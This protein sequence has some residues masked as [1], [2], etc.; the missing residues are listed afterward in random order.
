MAQIIDTGQA[1]TVVV[2]RQ[3]TVA[4][5]SVVSAPVQVSSPGPQ[6][7][8]GQDGGSFTSKVAA[9]ILG[10]H[11]VV[12]AVS[13]T[14]VNYATNTDPSHGDDI[15]GITMG[16]AIAGAAVLIANGQDVTEPSWAWTPLEPIYLG[17]NGLMTQIEP[18]PETGAEFVVQVGFATSPTSMR[19]S[20][21]TPIYY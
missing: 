21:D 8:P 17:T 5:V 10:G 12:R 18:V 14:E 6:G 7:V 16:A 9:A 11:R 20:I 4:A 1:H 15:V 3:N 13:A 2:Q 19:V